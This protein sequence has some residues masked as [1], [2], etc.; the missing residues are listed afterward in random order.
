[1]RYV[2]VQDTANK[3]G[4]STKMVSQLCRENRIAGVEKISGVWV[5]PDDA[6]KPY[7][8]REQMPDTVSFDGWPTG[9]GMDVGRS[10]PTMTLKEQKFSF[11]SGFF[12][13]FPETTHVDILCCEDVNELL[14]RPCQAPAIPQN[15]ESAMMA[16][17]AT[18]SF[19]WCYIRN[20]KRTVKIIQNRMA[21][22]RIYAM[23]HCPPSDSCRF[24]AYHVEGDPMN[25]LRIDLRRRI[26]F[27]G[28]ERKTRHKEPPFDIFIPIV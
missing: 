9:I 20:G 4:L 2:S 27:A 21:V 7:D 14:I 1:M 6:L 12:R 3:W 11:N 16:D 10:R 18:S 8:G 5:I 23:S 13:R 19:Q 26:G 24:L 28:V 22:E 15:G 17:K 25:A